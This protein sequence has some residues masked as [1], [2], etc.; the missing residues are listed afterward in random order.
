MRIV[1]RGAN[2][3]G[4]AVMTMPAIRRL[5][6]IYPDAHIALN[7]N[8]WA[9]GVFDRF[10][11]I[12]EIIPLPSSGSRIARIRRQAAD[13]RERRFD[14]SILF[15]NSIS[16]A[17]APSFAGIPE[18]IGYAGQLRSM[19][20]TTRI[21]VPEWKAERHE[22]L[23]YLN[24]IDNIGGPVPA[25]IDPAMPKL[26]ISGE[27]KAAAIEF[28]L[29]KGIAAGNAPIAIGPGSTNSNAKRWPAEYFARLC[30]LIAAS[31]PEVPILIL[32]AASDSDAAKKVVSAAR[33]KNIRDLT[34]STD[35]ATAASV[36]S[37]CRLFIS[38]DMGLS[39]LSAAAGTPTIVIFG[40]TNERS[41]HPLGPS[42][43]IIREPVE[44]APCM[45]RECPIDHR[46]MTRISGERVYSA[47]FEII[48]EKQQI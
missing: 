29:S 44:C 31:L 3:I 17:L 11:A 32:G 28:L 26:E 10:D 41:T 4:D 43:R 2:W 12:D 27:Q 5:R 8:E 24:L 19:L 38:N 45:L 9:M 48:G 37:V 39:H 30:D 7:I 46:C 42:V 21:A 22:S 25:E 34:G 47:A 20:L 16:S 1:I 35:L 6:E 15:T 18:R 36:L 40:P 14:V 23:F 33:T 13:L